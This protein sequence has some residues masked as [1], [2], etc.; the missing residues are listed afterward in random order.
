MGQFM[1]KESDKVGIAEITYLSK[2]DQ[3]GVYNW[4]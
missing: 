3:V 1:K 2:S 4:P